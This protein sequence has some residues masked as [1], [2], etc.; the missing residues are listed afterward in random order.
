[1]KNSFG[2]IG[3]CGYIGL[4]HINV[5]KKINGELIAY[6]DLNRSKE[7]E[8]EFGSKWFSDLD[9][10]LNYLEDQSVDY[11]VICS[12][13]NLHCQQILKSL[14]KNID[15]ICEKP[16]VINEIE[17]NEVSKALKDS[18]AKLF[19]IMQLRLHPIFKE[20]VN[21][22]EKSKNE[23]SIVFTA[24]RKSDY[25]DSW[26]TDS[27]MSG[28]ILFN[29]G[30]HY[31]DLMLSVFG[32]P[33]DSE[34]K[35]SNEREVSGI[36]KFK[37]LNLNWKFEIVIDDSGNLTPIREFI[38][39]GQIFNFSNV[40]EDLHLK[41]YKKIIEEKSFNFDENDLTYKYLFDINNQENGRS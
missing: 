41:N 23:A 33:V 13:N 8:R 39:N 34:I 31:F 40:S 32:Y 7:I 26:K 19:N 28:G 18:Q 6:C 35:T 11:N 14:K 38:I 2:I 5:I 9:D 10:Y 4:R 21:F 12:P 15:V 27:S 17:F 36:T 37:N 22:K 30:I 16:L 25:L 29:L 1:M 3:A 20:I 24:S